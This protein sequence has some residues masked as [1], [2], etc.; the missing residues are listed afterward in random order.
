MT[1]EWKTLP[2]PAP[3][4]RY[5]EGTPMR[6]P[7]SHA[8]LNRAHAIRLFRSLGWIV[9]YAGWMAV[10][11]LLVLTFITYFLMSSSH[12]PQGPRFEDISEAYAANELSLMGLG[13]TLFVLL[14]RAL[15]PI[16]STTPE[17]IF[18]PARFEK[19]FLPGFA[20]GALLAA[21]VT[22]AFLLGGAYR[23]LGFFVQF[24]EA[25]LAALTVLVRILALGAFAYSEEFVF[26]RKITDGLR[27]RIWGGRKPGLPGAILISLAVAGP[28]VLVKLLQF[29][30][31]VMQ[32]ITLALISLAL[33]AR[34]LL[35]DDFA[36]GA[37]FWAALL[38]VFQGLLSLPVL[39]SDFSGL[40]LI[41]HQSAQ[42]ASATGE[43][44]PLMRWI[45]GGAGGPLSS[46]A[47]QMLIVVDIVRAA[48]VYKKRLPNASP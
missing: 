19:R 3:V 26:R 14:L 21:G 2:P 25:P 8:L 6:R 48:R 5:N 39:G 38:I 36:R 12:S 41:K 31:G 20:H 30:L 11:R 9:A 43:A 16:T 46:V 33:S 10:F 24:E 40:L 22:L 28:Y 15:H 29:D 17:E 44:D 18:T 13:A 1:S 27:A 47:L 7:I 34:A 4:P 35:D 23:Y 45:T 37:G 42:D 32:A